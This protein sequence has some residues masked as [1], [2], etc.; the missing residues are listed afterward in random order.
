MI[1]ALTYVI[2]AILFTAIF[3]QSLQHTFVHF[4]SISILSWKTASSGSNSAALL[5]IS[6]YHWYVLSL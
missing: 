6:T 1:L 2:P 5:T 3:L 4:L